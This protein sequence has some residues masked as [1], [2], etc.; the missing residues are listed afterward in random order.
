MRVLY[1]TRDYTP[2][3]HRF[4]T[5]LAESGYEVHYL[6]L[7]QRGHQLEDRSLP[8]SVH[9]VQWRGGQEPFRWSNFPALFFSLRKV[10]REL[11]PDIVQ[12]GPLQTAA[13]LAALNGFHPL[14][15][16]PW[17]Y[18]LL[19][20]AESSTL[21]RW[22]TR[23]VLRRAQV[24]IGDCQAVH[25]KAVEFGV[26]TERVY[27][28]PWGIDLERFHPGSANE[29]RAR[30]GWQNSFVVLSLRSWEPVYGVDVMLRGFARACQEISA[31]GE[32]APDLRLLMLGGG[33]QASLVHRI[34]QENGLQERVFLGGQVRQEDLPMMYHAADLYLSAAHSDGSSVSLMEALGSG[35]PVL[36]T[37]IPSNREWVTQ[38][39]EGW[40]FPDSDDRAVADCIVRAARMKTEALAAIRA[41]SRA[42]AEQRA[43]WKDN[44][45]VLLAAYQRAMEIA[46]TGGR[47]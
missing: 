27:A 43:N 37:D 30:H 24:L 3:D 14:A 23:F 34:I 11:K 44:F 25:D 18:D 47:T 32:P 35:L 36:I 38:G 12:A 10:L 21:Y 1:F 4:L 19:K 46:R 2:H 28:F 20:D 39:K 9:L 26:P 41:N 45:Q 40:L 5:S 33:S 31:G 6:R 7:E 8:P 16:M 17:G 29:F 22:I 13:F 15:A 42:R